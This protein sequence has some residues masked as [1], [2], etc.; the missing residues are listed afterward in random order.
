[1]IHY[2]IHCPGHVRVVRSQ[3]RTGFRGRNLKIVSF[4][5]NR[6][7]MPVFPPERRRI[8]YSLK[9]IMPVILFKP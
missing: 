5:D 2:V 4:R 9:R 1:M 6:P 7:E 3:N 8:I